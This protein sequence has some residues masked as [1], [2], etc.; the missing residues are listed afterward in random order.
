MAEV[1]REIGVPAQSDALE[2]REFIRRM[3]L[4][5]LGLPLTSGAL[6]SGCGGGGAA[7]APPAG[8]LGN[9]VADTRDLIGLVANT[10][11]ALTDPQDADIDG[12]LGQ[13]NTRLEAV[14]PLMVAADGA[15][16]RAN[17]SADMVSVLGQLDGLGE[18]LSYAGPAPNLS[19]ARLQTAWERADGLM[20]TAPT[21]VRTQEVSAHTMWSFLFLLFLLFP[22]LDCVTATSYAADAAA[23]DTGGRAEELYELL[24]P[25]GAV[26]CTPCLFS[27]LTSVVATLCLYLY[28][29]M[30]AQAAHEPGL[31]FGR[32]WLIVLVLIAALVFL[33]FS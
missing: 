28:L 9:E 15:E 3:V 25:A 10:I 5:G 20:P 12:W 19:R 27:H 24:H 7:P 16:L 29:G 31:L 14:W 6:L 32:D 2:R 13:I 17:V 21:Q 23:R 22:D 18:E 30:G 8:D 4:A 1:R 11:R 26:G 33:A